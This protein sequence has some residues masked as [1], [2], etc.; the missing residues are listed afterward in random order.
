MIDPKN[1]NLR[2]YL[3]EEELASE[4]FDEAVTNYNKLLPENC[5]LSKGELL[6]V[7]LFLDGP[8]SAKE[9]QE[10]YYR[11]EERGVELHEIIKRTECSRS[12]LLR[13]YTFE[14]HAAE[15]DKD[16]EHIAWATHGL[17]VLKSG[18]DPESV[19]F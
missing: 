9:Y 4:T 16:T 14:L 1:E 7:S 15:R 17:N 3:T 2:Q 11:S 13:D 8:R 6:D 19:E 18:G 10:I 5:K 12:R